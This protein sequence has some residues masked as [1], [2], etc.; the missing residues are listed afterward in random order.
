MTIPDQPGCQLCGWV[1]PLSLALLREPWGNKR[2]QV[3]VC[4]TCSGPAWRTIDQP[5]P[6]EI[7]VP[8]DVLGF[9]KFCRR[10]RRREG[11]DVSDVPIT[12]ILDACAFGYGVS[13]A[14]LISQRRSTLLVKPRHVACFLVRIHT[15]LSYPEIGA[16]LGGRDRT[17]VIHAFRKIMDLAESDCSLRA[18]IDAID[19]TLLWH[20]ESRKVRA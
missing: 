10:Y 18:E 3:K 20:L 13:V 11:E 6:I 14:D 17:T 19:K 5:A 1:R 7:V 9:E 12:S 4:S 15:D 8:D 16:Q 2:V